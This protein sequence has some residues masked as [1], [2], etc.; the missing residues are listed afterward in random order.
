MA[1]ASQSLF[2]L[3]EGTC[4]LNVFSTTASSYSDKDMLYGEMLVVAP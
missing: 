4:F 1:L 3:R 2:I